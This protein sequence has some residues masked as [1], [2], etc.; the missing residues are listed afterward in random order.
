MAALLAGSQPYRLQHLVNFGGQGLC[1]APQK[2]VG[3][4][5][6][7]TAEMGQIV[8]GRV[9]AHGLEFSEAFDAVY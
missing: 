3:S 1:Q 7:V 2:F 9:A 4:E 6:V 5:A 8:G